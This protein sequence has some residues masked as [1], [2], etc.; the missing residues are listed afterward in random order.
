MQ[1]G[2]VVATAE[3]L[4]Y[5]RQALLGELFGQIHGNLSWPSD[6]RGALLGVHVGD[7]DLVEVSHRFLGFRP[8]SVDFG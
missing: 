4:A 1:H 3:E 5:F 6:A 8:K 2:S 7:L